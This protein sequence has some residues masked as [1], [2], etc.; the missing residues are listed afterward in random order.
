MTAGTSACAVAGLLL[1]AGGIGTVGDAHALGAHWRPAVHLTPVVHRPVASRPARYPVET[2]RWRPLPPSPI[3][4]AVGRAPDRAVAPV[5]RMRP[6]APPAWGQRFASA[7]HFSLLPSQM[8][9][10]VGHRTGPWSA[11]RPHPAVVQ[12]AP[13]PV[14]PRWPASRPHPGWPRATVA[15]QPVPH[16]PLLSARY[17]TGG[18]VARHRPSPPRS[19]RPVFRPGM[20][21]PDQR[22]HPTGTGERWLVAEH[23]LRT[24]WRPLN[25]PTT[26]VVARP[27]WRPGVIAA[28]RSQSAHA[29]FRPVHLARQ[30]RTARPAGAILRVAGPPRLPTRTTARPDGHA[31]V[32]DGCVDG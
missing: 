25:G 20:P 5:R 17:S 12:V 31:P 21:V 3:R 22:R 19:W 11:Q 7:P 15:A 2:A 6:W 13:P 24:G 10:A 18:L 29:R 9:P 14:A 26:R 32:C 28:P 8:G 4:L 27:L 1:A 30:A 23:R 16:R